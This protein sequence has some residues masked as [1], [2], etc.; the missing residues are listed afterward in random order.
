MPTHAHRSSLLACTILAVVVTDAHAQSF[1]SSCSSSSTT[2]AARRTRD[3]YIF[4]NGRYV[5]HTPQPRLGIN[6]STKRSTAYYPFAHY[7]VD[8]NGLPPYYLG[9]PPYYGPGA[10]A[11]WSS[12]SNYAFNTAEFAARPWYWR[13]PFGGPPLLEIARRID[14]ALVNMPAPKSGALPLY[15]S[16]QPTT[17]APPPVDAAIVALANRNYERAAELFMYRAGERNALEADDA[18]MQ[19]DRTALRL[20][21]LA[22]AGLGHY[23]DAAKAFARAYAED[24]SLRDDPMRGARL[25]GNRTELRRIVNGAVSFAYQSDS[26]DAWRMV[27][28]LMQAQGREQLAQQMLNRANVLATPTPM[29]PAAPR[30]PGGEIPPAKQP[31]DAPSPG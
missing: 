7:G 24:S 10:Y 23:A 1:T 27:A 2:L 21:A 13:Q 12:Y 29:K 14:P 31:Q 26:P 28:T 20:R 30:V 4:I 16:A 25:I 11:L 15:L 9:Y 17:P 22:L 8:L 18:S 6:L 5:I 19:P 3:V